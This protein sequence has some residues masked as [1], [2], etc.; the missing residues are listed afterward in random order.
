MIAREGPL[1]DLI[2][3]VTPRVVE[4]ALEQAVEQAREELAGRLAR[5]IV[6]RALASGQATA[7]PAGGRARKT[8]DPAVTTTRAAAAGPARS[9][10]ATSPASGTGLYAFAIIP[11]RP[12]DLANVPGIDGHAPLHIVQHNELGLVVSE[13]P[14]DLMADVSEDDLS[15]TGPL[16]TLARRHDEVIRTVFENGPVL[17][18]R[19]GTVVAD[20]AGARR[21]L[22]EQSTQ[23]R[24]RLAH[25]DTHREWGVRL[26]RDPAAV[27]TDPAVTADSAAARRDMTGTSYLAA[28]RE[29][30]ERSQRAEQQT[31]ALAAQVEEALSEQAVD[32]AYRG[33]GA[34][35][36]VLADLAYLVPAAREDAFLA[37]AERLSGDVAHEGLVLEVTGPWP[38]YSFATL[39][40]E[41]AGGA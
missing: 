23:A 16:A 12:V 30:L 1:D 33:G 8:A 37:A 29:A 40:S 26:S 18:L 35:S 10:A 6:D 25:L 39:Q 4:E 31:A 38:P 20:E 15:E 14:L 3:A 41:G 28:R 2:A 17:P 19:F 9:A 32:L 36:G 34:G 11:A 22:E 5:A 13:M 24:R 7:S 27:E 21:L